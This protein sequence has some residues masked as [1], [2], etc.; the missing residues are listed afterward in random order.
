MPETSILASWGDSLSPI[1]S[2][3][4]QLSS[5]VRYWRRLCGNLRHSASPDAVL[6][7]DKNVFSELSLQ[8]YKTEEPGKSQILS[9][10]PLFFLIICF[11]PW[12]SMLFLY[13]ISYSF[14]LSSFLCPSPLSIP[15]FFLSKC[16]W[17]QLYVTCTISHLLLC[18]H[19]EVKNGITWWN[20]GRSRGRM[21]PRIGTSGG[22]LWTR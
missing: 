1:Q 4:Q 22:L 9:S 16:V 19:K 13:I 10:I 15:L 8:I 12:L 18:M 17:I 14:F 21:W 2:G 20:L 11:L 5:Q 6:T 3:F 7:Q